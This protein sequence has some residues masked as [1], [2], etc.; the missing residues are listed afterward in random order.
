MV[1]LINK[2]AIAANAAIITHRP[3]GI[4]ICPSMEPKNAGHHSVLVT[5]DRSVAPACL[6]IGGQ[7]PHF[8]ASRFDARQKVF[9]LDQIV[10]AP[11]SIW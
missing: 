1:K 4:A 11:G 3:T 6:K 10:G 9:D 7:R 8:F 5:R 2:N